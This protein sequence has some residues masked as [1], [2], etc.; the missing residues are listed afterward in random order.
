MHLRITGMMLKRLSSENIYADALKSV[1]EDIILTFSY[2]YDFSNCFDGGK[3]FCE[4]NGLKDPS[5][6]VR[7]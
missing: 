7:L 1:P 6:I 2:L 3:D 5:L 4:Q